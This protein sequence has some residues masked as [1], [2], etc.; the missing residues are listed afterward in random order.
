MR[1]I[2]RKFVTVL[3]EADEWIRKAGEGEIH[4]SW[5]S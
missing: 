1:Y 2:V 4:V 5:C 3:Q